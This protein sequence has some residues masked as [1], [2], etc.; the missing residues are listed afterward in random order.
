MAAHEIEIILSRQLAD[1]LTVPVFIVDPEGTLIFYNIP[2]ENILGKK[3]QDTGPMPV[4]EWG[5]LFVPH[6]EDGKDIQPEELPLVQTI[7]KQVPAHKT[8]WIKSLNGKS[9]KISVTSIPIIGRSNNFSG[10]MAI[11]WDNEVI[12]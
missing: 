9:T 2:A 11:F 1:C 3:F 5:T 7:Q 12:E 6:D 10:A 8:F 4:G